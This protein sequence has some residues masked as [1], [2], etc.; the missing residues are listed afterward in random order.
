VEI[1]NKKVVKIC[2]TLKLKSFPIKTLNKKP[3]KG[4]KIIEKTII[5]P[6]N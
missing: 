2:V 3:N 4:R 1:N 5:Y 6:F